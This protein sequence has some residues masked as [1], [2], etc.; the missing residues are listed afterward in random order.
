M[1]QMIYLYSIETVKTSSNRNKSLKTQNPVVEKKKKKN[2]RTFILF[3]ISIVTFS[4]HTRLGYQPE[5][6]KK[7]PESATPQKL[8]KK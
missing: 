8:Q 2:L 7:A 6:I 4:R 3:Y 5:P 1:I